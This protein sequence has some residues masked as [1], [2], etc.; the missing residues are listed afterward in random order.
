MAQKGLK[1]KIPLQKIMAHLIVR[2]GLGYEMAERQR[3]V[4]E[5]T[6][7]FLILV[8]GPIHWCGPVALGKMF[9]L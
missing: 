4:G 2:Y 9:F 3:R 6:S 7:L 5:I 8:S 1:L